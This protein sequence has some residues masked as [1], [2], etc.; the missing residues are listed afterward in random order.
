MAESPNLVHSDEY[1][2]NNS[3]DSLTADEHK[4]KLVQDST[5]DV[6]LNLLANPVKIT[7][8][9]NSSE[10]EPNKDKENDSPEFSSD[11]NSVKSESSSSSYQKTTHNHNET[12]NVPNVTFQSKPVS[13][14]DQRFRKI[15]LLRIFQEL[16]EKGIRI[17]TRYSMSSRL[18]DMEQEYEI[19]RSLQ[20]KRNGVK[21]Y[22][23]FLTNA[24]GAIEFMNESYNPF[25]FH[26]KGWSDHVSAGINDY[27]D[28]FG[29]LYE[30]YK[31]S[32]QKI[33]PEMKLMIM[34]ITSAGSFHAAN[35]LLKNSPGL[36]DVVKNNPH[37][38]NN[39]TKKMVNSNDNPNMRPPP[40]FV[41]SENIKGPNPAEFLSKMR[42]RTYGNQAPVAPPEPMS[43]RNTVVDSE[44][45]SEIT[46][47]TKR[48]GGNKKKG[49]NISI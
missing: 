9:D 16:E 13:E 41:P 44:S 15:E 24:V 43:T 17:S 2:F 32:G 10:Q 19:L 34:L 47:T 3:I 21:L 36:G 6:K 5:T 20:N 28:V 33:Q 25:D 18:E 22:K 14:G 37:F 42:E 30:K 35:T 4:P 26:L 29:E 7:F 8:Y 27:D 38:I 39:M 11:N 45:V 40:E 1:K 23:N 49:M 46:S 31:N 48:R 12:P